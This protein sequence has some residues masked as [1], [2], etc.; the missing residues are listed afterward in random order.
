MPLICVL[1]STTS[2]SSRD[3]SRFALSHCPCGTIPCNNSRICSIPVS[4]S[5]TLA[6]S[7]AS[8]SLGTM[9]SSLRSSSFFSASISAMTARDCT[10]NPATTMLAILVCSRSASS[11][12]SSQSAEAP[13]SMD[14]GGRAALCFSSALKASRSV[15]CSALLTPK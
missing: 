12:P 15:S 2:S 13:S 1:R 7:A 5:A 3:S 10:E 8:T 11:T 9:P 6:C 4:I 14:K